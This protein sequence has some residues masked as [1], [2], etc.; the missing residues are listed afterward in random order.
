LEARPPLELL[1][2]PAQPERITMIGELLHQALNSDVVGLI[3]AL[4]LLGALAYFNR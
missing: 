3:V 2:I 1:A 4:G